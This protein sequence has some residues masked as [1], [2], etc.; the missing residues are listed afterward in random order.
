MIML[1]NSIKFLCDKPVSLCTTGL[2]Q[3]KLEHIIS[4]LEKELEFKYLE[5]LFFDYIV[6]FSA[7]KRWTYQRNISEFYYINCE[8]DISMFKSLISYNNSECKAYPSEIFVDRITMSTFSYEMTNKISL[9]YNRK[10]TVSE[11][12]QHYNELRKNIGQ[13]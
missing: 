13:E 4:Y 6:V 3:E 9:D 7:D 2:S 5:S 12:I 11:I 10:A 1:P 8:N